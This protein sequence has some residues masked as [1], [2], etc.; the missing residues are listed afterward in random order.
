MSFQ[1]V[2]ARIPIQARPIA[3]CAIAID[4]SGFE[5][6]LPLRLLTPEPERFLSFDL[7]QSLQY[8]LSDINV[9]LEGT[10]G[11][12]GWVCDGLSLVIN[13]PFIRDLIF[14]TIQGFIDG[15]LTRANL[16]LCRGLYLSHVRGRFWLP[17]KLGGFVLI[18]NVV[19]KLGNVWPIK[20]GLDG[21]LDVG[22]LAEQVDTRT[23]SRRGLSGRRGKLC[24]G[25][26]RWHLGGHGWWC[27][28]VNAIDAYRRQAN[29]R[30]LPLRAPC[31]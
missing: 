28:G 12:L 16:W 15:I 10:G 20:L 29:P 27:R 2:S 11:V 24:R 13:F 26:I 5:V 19:C 9:R 3:A 30:L 7:E 1:S 8:Q 25:R 23:R 17:H 22:S 31:C 21:Q 14:D 6:G 18:S 4:G